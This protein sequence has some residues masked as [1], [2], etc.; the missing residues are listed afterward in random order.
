MGHA[1]LVGAAGT[2]AG[3]VVLVAG[4]YGNDGYRSGYQAYV[5][6]VDGTWSQPVELADR[7][8]SSFSVKVAFAADGSGVVSWDDYADHGPPVLWG[9]SSALPANLRHQTGGRTTSSAT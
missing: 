1:T 3:Q 8:L 7:R 6:A 9:R 5:R 4:E 2:D